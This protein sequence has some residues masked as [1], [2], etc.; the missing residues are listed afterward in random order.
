MFGSKWRQRIDANQR[1]I[2]RNQAIIADN[3][4]ALNS[5]M[6]GALRLAG[7]NAESAGRTL[8]TEKLIMTQLDDLKQ[9]AA[10]LK[11]TADAE[12]TKLTA[13]EQKLAGSSVADNPDVAAVIQSLQGTRQT[14][15]TASEGIDTAL[16]PPATGA[17]AAATS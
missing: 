4:V 13:L 5:K 10:D 3:Q 16:N 17:A 8:E 2:A 1:A 11:T 15:Q 7:Q 6:A 14:L 12:V 9:V